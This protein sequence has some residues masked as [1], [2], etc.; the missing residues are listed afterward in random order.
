MF[1]VQKNEVANFP[2]GANE[3]QN[4]G[5]DS[6]DWLEGQLAGRQLP[7]ELAHVLVPFIR[8]WEWKEQKGLGSVWCA[9]GGEWW[10]GGLTGPLFFP[11]ARGW[12]AVARNQGLR[13]QL[14]ECNEPFRRPPLGGVTCRVPR[15]GEKWNDEWRRGNS[16]GGG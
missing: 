9:V 5:P 6:R 12:G 13:R 10:G 16:E 11:V 7:G 2:H 14:P 1:E 4:C 3:K 15:E 8:R